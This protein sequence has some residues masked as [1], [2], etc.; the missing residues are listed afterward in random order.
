[1]IISI[2]NEYF[3]ISHGYFNIF[4]KML[5]KQDNLV[6]QKIDIHEKVFQKHI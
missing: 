6:I 1:M 5:V 2:L 3:T 4:F